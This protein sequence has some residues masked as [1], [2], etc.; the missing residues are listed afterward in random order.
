MY[1]QLK[2][3][4]FIAIVSLVVASCNRKEIIAS[5]TPSEGMPGE[6]LVVSEDISELKDQFEQF[7]TEV[8]SNLIVA[9]QADLMQYEKSISFWFAPAKSIEGSEK[10]APVILVLNDAQKYSSTLEGLKP[11]KESTVAGTSVSI[12]K[13]VWANPQT[14]VYIDANAKELAELLKKEGFTKALN[15]LLQE[16]IIGQGLPGSLSSNTYTDSISKIIA[17]N[18]GFTFDFPAQFRLEYTNPEIVWLRQESN[19]FYR[20]IFINIF[21]DSAP[22]TTKEAAIQNRDTFTYKYLSNSE[23]TKV[24]VSK[25]NLFKTQFTREKINGTDVFV[26]RGWYQEELTFRRGPFIRYFFHDTKNHRYIAFDCF[27]YA[28]EQNRLPFYRLF[29]IMAQG[30]KFSE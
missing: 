23:G 7:F 2:S 18:Y 15:A 30:F 28:P 26:L 9:E 21:R 5:T 6:V 14:A 25:S 8:D 16:Q 24:A 17:S 10:L 11:S 13:N 1:S 4:I 3:I 12:F 29:E 22:I 27:L 20:H 19:K